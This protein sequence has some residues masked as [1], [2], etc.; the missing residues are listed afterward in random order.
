MIFI[1]PLNLHGLP[2]LFR[3]G[4]TELPGRLLPPGLLDMQVVQGHINLGVAGDILDGLD[5]HTQHLH[6]GNEGMP[7][8]VRRYG[9]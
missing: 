2:G 3:E 7:T 5:V 6:H 4:L 9:W 8:A 1:G